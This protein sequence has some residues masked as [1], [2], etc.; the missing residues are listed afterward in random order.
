MS[1]PR[2]DAPLRTNEGFRSMEEDPDHHQI[3]ERTR[4]I[5]VSP[6]VDIPSLDM[7]KDFPVSD[8]LH[9]LHSGIFNACCAKKKFFQY[10]KRNNIFTK[11]CRK[12]MFNWLDIWQFQ[13]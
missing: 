4:K 6:L 12:K 2:L 5:V 13:F 9:L 10:F 1:F 7:I 11:R 8:E 3:D